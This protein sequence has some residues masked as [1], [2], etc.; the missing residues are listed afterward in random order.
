MIFADNVNQSSDRLQR[1]AR[2]LY[3]KMNTNGF[4]NTDSL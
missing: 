3:L 2:I 1:D 4:S